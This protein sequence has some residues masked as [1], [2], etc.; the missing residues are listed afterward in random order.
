MIYY[1]LMNQEEDIEKQ[2]AVQAAETATRQ[3]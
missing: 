3:Q 2:A 1:I